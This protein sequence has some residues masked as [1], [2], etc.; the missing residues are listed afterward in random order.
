[1]KKLSASYFTGE[2]RIPNISGSSTVETANLAYL[3]LM[4]A[5]YEKKFLRGLLG[6][7]LFALYDAEVSKTTP[8]TSGIYFDLN[9]QI[10]SESTPLYESP[11]AGYVYFHYW[12][13]KQTE[14]VGLGESASRLENADLVS[15]AGKMV[16]AWN[17]MSEQVDDVRAWIEEHLTDYPTYSS[18]GQENL[19]KITVL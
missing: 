3:T 12:R 14:T 15:S 13:S 19:S 7:N 8:Q 1:M 4:I 10:Y 17:E 11:A 16:A 9:A 6:D 5:K 18:E 2:L